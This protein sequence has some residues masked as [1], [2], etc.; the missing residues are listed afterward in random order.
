MAASFLEAVFGAAPKVAQYKP[1]DFTKE[2]LRATEGNI[3]NFPEFARLGDLYS[4]YLSNN[5]EKLLP[6]YG[7][8]LKSGQKI[9]QSLLDASAPLLR[10]EIPQDV[11]DQVMRS[12][13]YQSLSGGFSGSQMAHA[14]TARDLGL[15]S[16]NLKDKGAQL[17][18]AGGNSAQQWSK[19]AGE[20]MFNPSSMFV[21]PQ[22]R[23]ELDYK[24]NIAKQ[25]TKQF[26]YNVDA[27]PNPV[28]KGISDTIINLVGAYLGAGK[29]GSGGTAAN[30]NTT[31]SY[32]F[33]YGADVNSGGKGY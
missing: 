21:T 3:E 5:I 7:E 8:T 32:N 28:A 6:G 10:G 14:L 24:N 17:A 13:A 29:G 9:T 18:L 1:V 26:Q 25:A 12:S 27:A 33:N 19:L 31:G 20:L 22:Q 23:A 16:L 30:Y 11:K 4:K 15:T 2:Q